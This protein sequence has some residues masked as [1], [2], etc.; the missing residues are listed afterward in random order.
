MADVRY[1]RERRER[2]KK[3]RERKGVCVYVCVADVRYVKEKREGEE[4]ERERK[5]VF[6][7]K[8]VARFPSQC[9]S[10][11]YSIWGHILIYVPLPPISISSLTFFSTSLYPSFVSSLLFYSLFFLF[12]KVYSPLCVSRR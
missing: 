12:S 3:G 1:V 2:E 6:L 5:C 4:G 8:A 9:V 7:S 11:F 10:V